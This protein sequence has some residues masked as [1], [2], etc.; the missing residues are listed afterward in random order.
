MIRKEEKRKIPALPEV[1]EV[2]SGVGGGGGGGE[3]I[4]HLY[5]RFRRWG[6]R[7]EMN[8]G[9]ERKGGENHW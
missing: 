8:P 3:S 6:W 7:T 5:S 4:R 1:L 2:W 9:T